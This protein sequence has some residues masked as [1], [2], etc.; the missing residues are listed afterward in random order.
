MSEPKRISPLLDGFAVGSL[1][2]EHNGIV[3]YPAIKEGSEKKYILKVISIP[4]SQKQMDA[5]ILSGAYKDAEGAMGYYKRVSEEVLQEAAFLKELSQLE[6]FLAYE[7]WQMEPITKH[8]LG[9]EVYLLGS[10]K[11]SLDKYVNQHPM[12][13]LEAMNLALDLC[14]ALS[15][16]RQA[17]F[18]YVDLKP[19]NIFVSEN[20][21]YRIGDLG[22]VRLTA[23]GY[24]PLPEKYHSSYSAPELLDPMESINLTVDTYALGM[25]LYQLYNEGQL[26]EAVDVEANQHIPPVNADY[27]LAEII[28]KAIHPEVDARWQD[29][30]QMGQAIVAYMQRNV[31]KDIPI[32]P[33]TPI[34]PE[35][36]NVQIPRDEEVPVS[37]PPVQEAKQEVAEESAEAIIPEQPELPVDDETEPT[38]DELPQQSEEN[39]ILPEGQEVLQDEIPETPLLETADENSTEEVEVAP[40]LAHIFAKADDLISHETPGGVVLP[41]LPDAPDPFAFATEDSIEF[42]DLNTPFDPVMEDTS[43]NVATKEKKRSGKKFLSPERKRRVKRFFRSLAVICVLAILAMAGLWYYQNI[44]LLNIDDIEIEG[45]KDSLSVHVVSDVQDKLLQVSCSDTYGN[46]ETVALENGRATFTQLLPNTTYTVRVEAE[47]FHALVGQ[48]SD[49][50]TTEATTDIVAFSAITGPED[51]S[52]V[53]NF[54][55]NGDEPEEWTVNVSAAGEENRKVTFTGHSTTI[56]GLTLGKEYIFALDAGTDLS[57]S[58]K[59]SVTFLASRII[60]AQ[61]LSV[62]TNDGTDMTIRWT[63][64]G[65]TIVESWNVRCYNDVDYDESITVTDTEVYLTNIDSSTAYTVEVTAAGM[66]QPARTSIT[67]N[68][69]NITAIHVD[70]SAAD[71][72]TVS[73][74]YAGTTPDE[75]WLL[76]YNIDG[77]MDL[78]VIKCNKTSAVI[79]PKIP[80]A[81]YTFTI[82][83]VEGIS[84]FNNI[85]VYDCPAG[86]SYNANGVQASDFKIQLLKTPENDNWSYDN[87]DSASYTDQ[88]NVGDPISLVLYAEPDFYLPGTDITVTYVIRDA[89]GNIIPEYVFEAKENWRSI[90]YTGSYHYGELNM[91]GVIEEPGSYQMQIYID[92]ASIGQIGFTIN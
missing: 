40:E 16:C 80:E 46:M 81:K 49:V 55:V 87:T 31:I 35:S 85:H 17:G 45:G 1:T 82:Q 44:Y 7:G 63:T 27:E 84:V 10:Y 37:Q 30:A 75:G 68:P 23:R 12:T 59:S 41:E 69:V 91:P 88:F 26:P 92:G 13:H 51:G 66:T 83:T 58:G 8:R 53:L 52:A 3:C 50:Y 86:P 22:F 9:Y 56:T 21:E 60:Y 77:T 28:L 29:P 18:I 4:A 6:G 90:W 61:N 15:V 79:T 48:T 89:Y 78:N 42:A 19:Q 67:A 76:M 73:W 36:Q 72:L 32:T 70:D 14:N 25:I 71:K 33:Y 5:M 24:T 11:R 54:T 57:V 38:E 20:K 34:D 74:E 62:V 43:G 64:P 65:D 2:S 47:G 39:E